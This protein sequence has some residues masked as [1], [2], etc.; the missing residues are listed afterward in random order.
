M[1]VQEDKME[2]RGGEAPGCKEQRTM[3][4]QTDVYW[5]AVK[6]EDPAPQSWRRCVHKLSLPEETEELH[7]LL[8]YS[9]AFPKCNSSG[10][11]Q[12][13]VD[14]AGHNTPLRLS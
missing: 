10:D 14:G 1:L 4:L 8:D 12:G 11:S 9:W 3:G 13:V 6:Q 7:C 2:R 5:V